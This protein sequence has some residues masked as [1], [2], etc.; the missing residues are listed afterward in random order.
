M[1]Q[2]K[3]FYQA[4]VDEETRTQVIGDMIIFNND[5]NE[6][7]L[8]HNEDLQTTINVIIAQ[9]NLNRYDGEF[10]I[11]KPDIKAYITRKRIIHAQVSPEEDQTIQ[12]FGPL[13]HATIITKEKEIQATY[14]I[15]RLDNIRQN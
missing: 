2:Y 12:V 15:R 8:T 11:K 6:T 5:E 14:M 3:G 1:K 7:F 10:M 4:I 9:Y 13:Y